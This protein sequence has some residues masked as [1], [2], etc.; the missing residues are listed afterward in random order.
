MIGNAVCRS[1]V[2][3]NERQLLL[4]LMGDQ[5]GNFP[6]SPGNGSRR[7]LEDWQ[8]FLCMM[9]VGNIEQKNML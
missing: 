5:E 4:M 6:D 8:T 3:E 9:R 7:P 1:D 2:M